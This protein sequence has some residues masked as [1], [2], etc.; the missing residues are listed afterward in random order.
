MPLSV[1][2][3]KIDPTHR[4]D[5]VKFFARSNLSLQEALR[6]QISMAA[7]CERCLALMESNAP[8]EQI[9]S[10]FAEILAY[11]KNTFHLNG[12]FRNAI[13]KS[14]EACNLPDNFIG[15]VLAEAE[16]I[17]NHEEDIK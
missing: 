4:E 1:Y 10:A 3:I 9:Q 11:A 12:L 16:K 13:E 6:A 17:Q 5:A 8:V 15:N 7:N 14:A 2:S